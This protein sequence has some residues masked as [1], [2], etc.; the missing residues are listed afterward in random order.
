MSQQQEPKLSGKAPAL[1]T[2][3]VGK[4][5]RLVQRNS[6]ASITAPA[7]RRIARR[8][9]VKRSSAA[10]TDVAREALSNFMSSLVG[11]ALV[12]MNSG[13]RKTVST[14]DVAHAATKR[15]RPIYG[16]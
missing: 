1:A 16:F 15:G 11:D 3:T 14:E 8:A 2:K 4:R 7:I 13:G 10:T 5:H 12:Y 6:I 9:G